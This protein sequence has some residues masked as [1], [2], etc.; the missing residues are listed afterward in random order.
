MNWSKSEINSIKMALPR[1]RYG[2]AERLSNRLGVDKESIEGKIKEL[3]LKKRIRKSAKGVKDSL[4]K[5]RGRRFRKYGGKLKER[6]R[7]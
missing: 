3:E 6:F 1:R 4:K 2:L 5:H 7:D